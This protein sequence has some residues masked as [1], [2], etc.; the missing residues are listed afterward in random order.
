MTIHKHLIT[1]IFFLVSLFSGRAQDIHP[2]SFGKGMINYIAKDSSW[3]VKFAPRMQF[4]SIFERDK[5]EDGYPST[6]SNFLIRRARLKFDGFAFS[7][8]LKYKIEL[9]LSNRDLAGASKFNR[10][11][12]RY[13]LDAVI[14][15]NFY[16]NFVLWAGQ[17]KLPGN[18]ERVVSSAN[19][20]LVDRSILNK[21]FNI[22]RDIGIQLRHHF[23]IGKSFLVREIFSLA[24]GE[25]RNLTSGNLG[26]YQYTARVEFLPFGKF[27]SKGDYVQAAIQKETKPKLSVGISYDLNDDAVKTRS[28]QGKYMELDAGNYYMTDITTWFV[29]AM[30]KYRGFSFMGEFADRHAQAPVAIFPTNAPSGDVV[31]E[32]QSIN[33]QMG[34]FVTDQLELAARYTS[35]KFGAF[36]RSGL[37]QEY[38]LGISKYISGHHLKVQTDMTWMRLGANTTGMMARL[39]FDLHF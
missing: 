4:L 14:K 22:D 32:G 34:Y 33:L 12:P 20:Q 27:K 7:P 16:N 25:G 24:Q 31:L 19:M 1:L 2:T 26:G 28:N 3:S 30:F 29:D 15:W 13:I 10:N 11:T 21:Y 38:T 5:T 8:K 6:G 37:E 18:R 23:Y 36:N 17:T 39:Q 9:G 35:A